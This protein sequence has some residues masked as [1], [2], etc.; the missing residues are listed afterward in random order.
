MEFG[1]KRIPDYTEMA[2]KEA[3]GKLRYF[4]SGNYSPSVSNFEFLFGNIICNFR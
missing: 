2:Y 3:V 1:T 4:L